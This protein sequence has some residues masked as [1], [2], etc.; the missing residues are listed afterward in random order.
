MKNKI[1]H[2]LVFI[3][4]DICLDWWWLWIFL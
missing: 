1:M 4:Y 2:Q 3:D